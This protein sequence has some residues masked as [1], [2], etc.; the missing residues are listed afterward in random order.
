MP[1]YNY[2]CEACSR[3][4]ELRHGMNEPAPRACP[5]CDARD[6]LKRVL[7]SGHG[8]FQLKGGGWFSQG[9]TGGGSSNSGGEY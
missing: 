6:T 4:L 8:G 3:E 1:I 7:K 9:Y 5:S 2:K